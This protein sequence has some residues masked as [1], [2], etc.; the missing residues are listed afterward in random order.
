MDLRE[1]KNGLK[2]FG[3]IFQTPTLSAGSGRVGC[4]FPNEYLQ[5]SVEE[6]RARE[7]R[8]SLINFIFRKSISYDL[9]RQKGL[10]FFPLHTIYFYWKFKKNIFRDIQVYSLSKKNYLQSVRFFANPKNIY[11]QSVR[12]LA[13]PKIIYLQS[14]RILANPKKIYLQSVRILANLRKL[15]YYKP[16]CIFRQERLF[17]YKPE[18][19]FRQEK[20]LYYKSRFIRSSEKLFSELSL[21]QN[22]AKFNCNIYSQKFNL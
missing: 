11:L 5:V 22:I 10:L 17:Y 14:V 20:S 8:S 3:D 7:N 4:I 15:F 9:F 13:N 21:Y 18:C 19:I 6:L 1:T 2:I 16:E 12:A